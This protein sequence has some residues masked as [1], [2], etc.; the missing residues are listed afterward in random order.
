M[1]SSKSKHGDQFTVQNVTPEPSEVVDNY[2][3]NKLFFIHA[4]ETLSNG[5]E[6]IGTESLDGFLFE[7]DVN[8]V[9]FKDVFRFMKLHPEPKYARFVIRSYPHIKDIFV[10]RTCNPDSPLYLDFVPGAIDEQLTFNDLRN[11]IQKLRSEKLKLEE[12]K[13]DTEKYI[14][15]L[16]K[17]AD[18][19]NAQLKPKQDEIENLHKLIA[20]LK[21]DPV[22]ER[23]N[24]IL[25]D[26]DGFAKMLSGIKPDVLNGD[27]ILKNTQWS[28][29]DAIQKSILEFRNFM[30]TDDYFSDANVDEKRKENIKIM[31]DI[32]KSNQSYI[33][34]DMHKKDEEMMVALQ[35]MAKVLGDG[36]GA[37]SR[38]QI[39]GL[40]GN[41]WDMIE[42]MTRKQTLKKHLADL[43]RNKD[44]D[45]NNDKDYK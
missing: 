1:L 45:D 33:S 3:G 35:T 36:K 31:K 43:L 24:K 26:M 44:K 29:I 30:E 12:E 20:N 4:I 13:R 37:L 32:G 10:G 34:D 40:T 9:K 39:Q 28:S 23:L 38:L 18:E 17:N 7:E 6:F 11:E 41:V 42:W 22:M 14:E 19:L 16:G 2:G 15:K 27:K 8:K 21:S 5:S 25:N